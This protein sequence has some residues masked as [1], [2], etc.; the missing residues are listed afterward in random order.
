MMI[1]H[2]GNLYLGAPQTFE[3]IIV[4][5]FFYYSL[6]ARFGKCKFTRSYPCTCIYTF[7]AS[8]TKDV[9][10]FVEFIRVLM[11]LSRS[12]VLNSLVII[13]PTLLKVSDAAS[14]SGMLLRVALIYQVHTK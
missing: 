9:I 7:S 13:S 4:Q 14:R 11:F 8:V 12:A 5:C 3:A 6:E 2:C 1:L 10:L